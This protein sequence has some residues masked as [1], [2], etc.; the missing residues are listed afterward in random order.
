VVINPFCPVSPNIFPQSAEDIIGAAIKRNNNMDRGN[1][2]NVTRLAEVSRD[3][4]Q[5]K[6]VVLGKTG[7]I[8]EQRYNLLCKSKALIL[9][10]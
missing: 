1:P 7:P 6:D 2:I 9:E 4:I 3:T 10:K 8:K 5:N